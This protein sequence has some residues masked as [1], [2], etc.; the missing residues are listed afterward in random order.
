[1]C[2]QLE[3]EIA[4]TIGQREKGKTRLCLL[5]QTIIKFVTGRFP[6]LRIFTGLLKLLPSQAGRAW[7]IQ[8]PLFSF[9]LVILT[10]SFLSFSP[11][12]PSLIICPVLYLQVSEMLL[13]HHRSVSSV[14]L[15]LFLSLSLS[16]DRWTNFTEAYFSRDY[17]KDFPRRVIYILLHKDFR[18]EIWW[19]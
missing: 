4:L 15:S 13:N 5:R 16:F 9:I 6:A 8:F 1:M 2:D 11:L 12:F 3:S 14:F 7:N 17:T 19:K 18:E 10:F